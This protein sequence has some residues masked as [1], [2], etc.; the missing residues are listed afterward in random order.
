MVNFIV[1]IKQKL[2]RIDIDMFFFLPITPHTHVQKLFCSQLKKEVL[3]ELTMSRFDHLVSTRI[4]LSEDFVISW[5]GAFRSISLAPVL[6]LRY[7]V[8]NC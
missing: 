8:S 1:E 6:C 4:F 7:Q 3:L 2:V 5:F